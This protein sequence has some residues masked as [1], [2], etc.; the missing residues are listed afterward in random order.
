[1]A[2]IAASIHSGGSGRWGDVAMP[3]QPQ[4]KDADATKLA[5]WILAGA[6]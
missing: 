4:V 1:V 6:K 3:P 2:H 5:A